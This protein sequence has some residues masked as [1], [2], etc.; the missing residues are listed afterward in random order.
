MLR[1]RLLI[2]VKTYPTLSRKHAET[3]CTA[4]VRAD[5]S[6]VQ[7]YPI[8][9][10]LMDYKDRYAKYDWIET[11]LAKSSRDPRPETFHPVDVTDTLYGRNMAQIPVSIKPVAIKE[12]TPQKLN[13]K[14]RGFSFVVHSPVRSGRHSNHR[15]GRR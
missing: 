5:G 10:R 1:E 8:P 7:L 6:W 12:M 13:R 14:P 15:P 3:V 11:T 9:F 2:T 4:A